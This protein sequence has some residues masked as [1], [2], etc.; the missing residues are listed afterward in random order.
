M[1]FRPSVNTQWA[2]GALPKNTNDFCFR[3]RTASFVLIGFVLATMILFAVFK[4]INT[5][6][7]IHMNIEIALLC[8]HFCLIPDL[9][10]NEV[11]ERDIGLLK[12]WQ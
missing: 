3:F 4:I 5:G 6:R 8:A 9:T 10:D 11:R 1:K 2:F 12:N 7:F